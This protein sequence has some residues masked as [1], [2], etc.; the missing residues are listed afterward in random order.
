MARHFLSTGYPH[1]AHR[2]STALST[3]LST[4]YAHPY[5]QYANRLYI[6]ACNPIELAQILSSI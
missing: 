3:G 2:I 5:P 6:A 4:A 1:D